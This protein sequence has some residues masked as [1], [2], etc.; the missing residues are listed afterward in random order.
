M[1]ASA[2]E[3][4]MIVEESSYGTPVATPTVWTTATT[5]G[6][7]NAE[8]YYIRLDEGNAFT[9]RGR[10]V[11]VTVPYGGGVA[12]PAYRVSD[13]IECKGKLK[14]KL[15]V[16]QAPFLLSWAGVQV[17]SGGTT[18]WTTTGNLAG[19]LASCSVY[20]AIQRSDGTYK[21]TLYPGVKVA[22]WSLTASEGSPV[23]TLDL[24][25]VGQKFE[26]NTYDS[27]LDPTSTVFPAPADD[28]F[29]SD[30]F[31]F[32]HTNSLLTIA[33]ASR[34]QISSLAIH[35]ENKLARSFF[36]SRW[37]GLL[38]MKGRTT[39]VAS[40]LL[41]AATPDDRTAYED[42]T[43]GTVSIGYNN[44]THG[45]VMN[46]NAQNIMDPFEDDLA[47]EDV[48]WQSNTENNLY[49]PTAGSDFTLAFT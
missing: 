9:M 16:S 32:I 30:P 18:P 2:R 27:S 14:V 4:L 41:Y 33:G 11:E 35:V 42:L 7:A 1:S 25:L 29:P 44:G 15:S 26:G 13:K 28:N 46:M 20:H 23:G 8:A 19:D 43:A 10:P 6:L 49:D 12:I 47:L 24:D 31:L 38:Q 39:T 21:R 40:K 45:F 36:N 5:Y 37:V 22:G 3:F 17:N 48:Y 34:S